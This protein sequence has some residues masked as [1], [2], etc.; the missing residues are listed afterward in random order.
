LERIAKAE[1]GV[2]NMQATSACVSRY[3]A[4]QVAPLDLTPPISFAMPAQL[5]PSSS[6]DRVAQTRRVSE[7][8]P[9]R[10]LAE[11]L[12][13]P[14]VAPGGVVSAW[15]PEAHDQ[16]HAAAKRRA[17]VLQRSRAKVEGRHGSLSLRRH[18]RRGL[19]VPRQRP[20]CTAMHNFFLAR[21][22]GTTA[23]ERFF[24]QKPRSMF[25]AI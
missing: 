16:L 2:P 6:L 24:S 8:E 1:R 3:V 15:G 11:R 19:D 18:Q 9:L 23:A 10:E 20:C 17:A 21:P 4:P 7:G 13:A 25:A 22:D 14:W 12:R 5:M